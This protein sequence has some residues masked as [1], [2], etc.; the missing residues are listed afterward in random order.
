MC[1]RYILLVS[2]VLYI[3]DRYIISVLEH[4]FLDLL[5]KPD[6]GYICSAAGNRLAP[7]VDMD[8]CTYLWLGPLTQRGLGL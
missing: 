7:M 3:Q 6:S 1:K 4:V 2:I 8:T 5:W